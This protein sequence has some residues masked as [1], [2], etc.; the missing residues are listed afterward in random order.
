[1]IINK[2]SQ[3]GLNLWDDMGHL[4]ALASDT[5]AHDADPDGRDVD[6][7]NSVEN[8]GGAVRDSLADRLQHLLSFIRLVLCIGDDYHL[9]WHIDETR[10]NAFLEVCILGLRDRDGGDYHRGV[11]LEDRGHGR[12]QAW[13][14]SPKEPDVPEQT[15]VAGREGCGENN[16]SVVASHLGC[17]GRPSEERRWNYQRRDYAADIHVGG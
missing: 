5:R 4:P 12:G 3:L 17:E 10:G 8:G 9:S 7:P 13:L 11:T 2:Q 15:S 6:G 1:M 14:V 16:H